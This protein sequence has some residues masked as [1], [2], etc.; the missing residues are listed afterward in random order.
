V[1][2]PVTSEERDEAAKRLREAGWF[3]HLGV[4]ESTNGPKWSRE[5]KRH[6][7][8]LLLSALSVYF[9]CRRGFQS[10]DVGCGG[11]VTV[12]NPCA[13]S[14]REC[15]FTRC[16]RRTEPTARVH[17]SGGMQQHKLAEKRAGNTG[18]YYAVLAE[19]GRG[20]RPPRHMDGGL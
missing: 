7:C 1:R 11:A 19:G 10:S 18:R 13:V 5:V 3:T 15:S 17:E 6:R 8:A 4:K 2:P 20:W 14:S 9:F 12:V 16:S